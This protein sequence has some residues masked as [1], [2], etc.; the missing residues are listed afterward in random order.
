MHVFKQI[1][2]DKD[3]TRDLPEWWWEIKNPVVL[4]V[5]ANLGFFSIFM[6]TEKP[7]ATIYAFEPMPVNFKRLRQH[8]SEF[9]KI[10][11]HIY[12]EAV[13]G[14]PG[15]LELFYEDPDK[16]TDTAGVVQIRTEDTKKMEVKATSIMEIISRFDLKKIDFLK[17]DCEG[18]EYDILYSL[19]QSAFDMISYMMIETHETDIDGHDHDS[20]FKF[21]SKKGFKTQSGTDKHTGYIWALGESD[22]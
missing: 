12:Q 19:P 11:L 18:S 21:V 1:F 20:L 10:D 8:Q 22:H 5:G 2:F 14:G 9:P 6:G 17:L 7:D 3:Y 15:T 4:D 16:F 13:S